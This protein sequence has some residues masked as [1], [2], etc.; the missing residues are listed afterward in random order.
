MMVVVTSGLILYSPLEHI[1]KQAKDF[2]FFL[3]LWPL[4]GIQF[5]SNCEASNTLS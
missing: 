3:I 2:F 5:S 4:R 1:S